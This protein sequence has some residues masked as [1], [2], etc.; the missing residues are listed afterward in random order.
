MT[1]KSPGTFIPEDI[2]DVYA[3]QAW[4]KGEASDDQQIRAYKWIVDVLCRTY[5]MSFDPDSDRQSCFS[6]GSRHVGRALVGIV[7]LNPAAL[8]EADKRIEQREHSPQI[9]RKRDK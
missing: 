5:G 6:E 7:A 9:K 4:A 8:K 2:Q 1:E 3:I